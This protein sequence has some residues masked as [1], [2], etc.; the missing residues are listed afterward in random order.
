MKKHN[1]AAGGKSLAYRAALVAV[2]SV[3]VV[4]GVIGLILP[5]IP[6]LLFLALAV[7]LASKL[8]NRIARW[9]NKVPLFRRWSKPGY[10]VDDLSTAQRLKLAFWF[11]ARYTVDSLSTI[12]RRLHP[13]GKTQ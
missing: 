11:S 8:S 1:T 7:M 5:I 10:A 3:C 13:R 12:S 9:A 4:L 6:G 2:I